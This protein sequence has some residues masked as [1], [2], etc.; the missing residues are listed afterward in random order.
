MHLEHL[1]TDE[2]KAIRET[3]RKFVE[4]EIMPIRDELEEDYSVVEG[5][6]QKLVDLGIQ[7]GGFPP[8]YGGSGPYSNMALGIICEE[9]ARGDAGISLSAGINAGL[10]M[11]PALVAGNKAVLDKFAPAF[12]GDK[13][14]YA[15]LS[16]TDSTGGADSENPLLRGSGIRTRALLDGDEYVINGT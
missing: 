4:K 8:E 7:K 13:V 16:M 14:C 12:C 5:V 1:L 9:L 6:H 3:V 2:E 15:C 10:L 11:G